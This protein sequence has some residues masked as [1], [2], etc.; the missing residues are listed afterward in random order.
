[1]PAI[2]NYQNYYKMFS[3]KD[4]FHQIRE[5]HPNLVIASDNFRQAIFETLADRFKRDVSD[6]M[7]NEEVTD[8]VHIFIKMVRRYVKEKRGHIDDIFHGHD[9]FW[10]K[11]VSFSSL[12]LMPPTRLPRQKPSKIPIPIRRKQYEDLSNSQKNRESKKVRSFANEKRLSDGSIIRAA[13]Q[14][15]QN[16]GNTGKEIHFLLISGKKLVK[17]SAEHFTNKVKAE[18][19]TS[20]SLKVPR[21]ISLC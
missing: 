8:F 16:K 6:I 18:H 7:E 11:E 2:I 20:K 17:C 12:T 19:F 10:S 3:K 1:M 4:L 14:C 5:K 9:V 13:A 15:F 21:N